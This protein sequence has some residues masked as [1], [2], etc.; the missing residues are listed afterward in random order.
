MDNNI[1]E[2]LYNLID[3]IENSYLIKKLES[4]KK[5]ISEDSKIQELIKIFDEKKKNFDKDL[6]IAKIN[7][8]SQNIIREYL[9][10]EQELNL[11]IIR[12]NQ[13]LNKLID[14]KGCR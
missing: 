4:N 13:K 2:A 5:E 14:K 12:L 10:C 6:Q 3:E 7:L 9:S 8:Y 1:R 11:I